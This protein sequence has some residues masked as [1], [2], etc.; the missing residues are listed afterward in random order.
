MRAT[1]F[2]LPPAPE[3]QA[4]LPFVSDAERQISTDAYERIVRRSERRVHRP[5]AEKPQVLIN[6]ELLAMPLFEAAMAEV[7]RVDPLDPGVIEIDVPPTDEDQQDKQE[8]IE[9]I[10]DRSERFVGWYL[11]RN[12][13]MLSSVGNPEEKRSVIEWIFEPDVQGQVLDT[14][15]GTSRWIPVFA[16]QIPFSFQWCCKVVGFKPE[17]MQDALLEALNAA[18]DRVKSKHQPTFEA[19]LSIA[20]EQ[21]E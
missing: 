5:P 6:I 11:E 8:A 18:R 1:G 4:V 12:L 21:T 14:R 19:L 7:L 10:A 16:D 3:A 15:N 17:R 9:W 2:G 20:K 13:E